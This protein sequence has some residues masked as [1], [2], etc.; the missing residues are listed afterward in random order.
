M[1][2]KHFKE[3]RCFIF[4]FIFL[5]TFNISYS[6]NDYYRS[7]GSNTELIDD[8]NTLNYSETIKNAI[9]VLH[10]II[11]YQKFDR[12]MLDES[13][14]PAD[15]LPNWN[16]ENLH[17]MKD[18][19]DFYSPIQGVRNT[20][21]ESFFWEA[22]KI[23]DFNKQK[24]EDK[25]LLV[26]YRDLE[27]LSMINKDYISNKDSIN[28]EIKR[29]FK[30]TDEFEKYKDLLIGIAEGENT[31]KKNDQEV[32]NIWKTIHSL[33]TSQ[34]CENTCSIPEHEYC[35]PYYDNELYKKAIDSLT[36]R[37][38]FLN[39]ENKK[40]EA[41]CNEQFELIPCLI[42]LSHTIY[43]PGIKDFLTTTKEIIR[44]IY[45][46][47]YKSDSKAMDTR[48]CLC[49]LL[50]ELGELAILVP[51]S[52]MKDSNLWNN[53]HKYR[54]ALAHYL[55]IHIDNLENPKY[56]SPL[57]NAKEFL[58][59]FIYLTLQTSTTTPNTNHLSTLGSKLG[60]KDKSDE[61]IKPNSS[62][63]KHHP[64]EYFKSI[65]GVN[66]L[67]HILDKYESIVGNIKISNLQLGENYCPF[68]DI[69][70]NFFE[71]IQK[72]NTNIF[73]PIY[74]HYLQTG[75]SDCL[76]TLVDKL[77]NSIDFKPSDKLETLISKITHKIANDAGTTPDNLPLQPFTQKDKTYLGLKFSKSKKPISYDMWD[78]IDPNSIDYF[79]YQ[80]KT[81]KTLTDQIKNLSVI[82]KYSLNFITYSITE[83]LTKQY[84]NLLG[85]D[86]CKIIKEYR[87][88]WAHIRP[89]NCFPSNSTTS[90]NQI[91]ESIAMAGIYFL[92]QDILIELESKILF[93]QLPSNDS[94][95]D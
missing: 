40:I 86:N 82:D 31:I 88:Y 2:A 5:A 70:F 54:G 62:N 21:L 84:E 15:A 14:R 30:E 17:R 44:S 37:K 25:A 35:E 64:K 65:E 3:I 12:Y 94:I 75:D 38:E 51:K 72:N 46:L 87:N 57:F 24:Q 23:F 32:Q 76:Y 47:T 7:C 58:L 19:I 4:I 95:A 63:P 68:R 93:K 91:Y 48:F 29:I 89:D 78:K 26:R 59:N 28:N 20:E 80:N 22:I 92:F 66:Y 45:L 49:M 13:D 73:Q 1:K 90:K 34:Q 53:F 36:R 10:K 69:L 79:D 39:L 11:R 9:K 55:P 81:I 85:E 60:Y 67:K 61:L 27:L 50:I 42:E 74:V 71:D 56:N 33:K 43:Y 83:I 16:T 52:I 8:I 77:L 6:T 41:Y 18:A